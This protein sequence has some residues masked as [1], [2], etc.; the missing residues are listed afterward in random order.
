MRLQRRLY[1][2]YTVCLLKFVILCHCKLISFFLCVLFYLFL[3]DQSTL[4]TILP[5]LIRPE[6]TVYYST[7][8]Y[9]NQ[10]T[11]CIILPVLI[12]PQSTLCTILPVL[13]RPR[14]HCVQFYLFLLDTEYTVYYSTCS[15]QNQ[16]TLC[17]CSY[18]T[19]STHHVLFYLFLL[20]PE[21][22]VYY[23]T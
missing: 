21:Y 19:Q 20:D 11:L 3:L 22:T 15:Y 14:V 2:I 8:S 6:Y 4:C 23:S 12:R 5:F 16:N 9:Q 7:C 10:S 1:G 17:T 18:Q 13:I